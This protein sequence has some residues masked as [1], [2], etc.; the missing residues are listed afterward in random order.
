M[1]V[2]KILCPAL[3]FLGLMG[4]DT[5]EAEQTVRTGLLDLSDKEQV[6][7][8][9]R[10]TVFK[11]LIQ[12]LAEREGWVVMPPEEAEALLSGRVLSAEEKR[13]IER[14]ENLFNEGKSLFTHLEFDESFKSLKEARDIFE[15]NFAVME[16]VTPLSDV[17]FYLG[18]NYL[19]IGQIEEAQEEFRKSIRLNPGRELVKGDY[20]P[21]VY[22]AFDK[23]NDEVLSSPQ[24]I[25]NIRSSPSLSEVYLDGQKVGVTPLTIKETPPGRHQFRLE[26]EGYQTEYREIEV[27]PGEV[28]DF[29][30]S[31]RE[32]G[33]VVVMKELVDEIEKRGARDNVLAHHAAKLG[34]ILDCRYL[35]VGRMTPLVERYLLTVFL[36]DV[37]GEK[38]IKRMEEKV[39]VADTDLAER[40]QRLISA[41]TGE[42]SDEEQVSIEKRKF[43]LPI[44][45]EGTSEYSDYQAEKRR[46]QIWF[47]S[48]VGSAAAC[49]VAA[50]V[51]YVGAADAED[52]NKAENQ[53]YLNSTSTE[54]AELHYQKLKDAA[55]EGRSKALYGNIFLGVGAAAAGSAIL[56]FLSFPEEPAEHARKTSV[57]PYYSMSGE[58]GF[59][60]S[61]N[62]NL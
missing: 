43:R 21:E 62:F 4:T 25:I 9:H 6:F 53:L 27:A 51:L 5:A 58:L 41:L 23:M 29:E 50:G 60:F 42:V 2:R 55:D 32:A 49:G 3:I 61:M 20:L 10:N 47:W 16:D 13:Q 33:G 46:S 39:D 28:R 19:A 40:M 11:G 59:V 36:F 7:E 34:R 44:E 24:P 37:W 57:V 26:K 1:K 31:L 38:M 52:T 18:L 48:S 22:D 56:A 45:I 35:T 30:I 8:E 14:A 17:Y 54:E 15:S 12:G